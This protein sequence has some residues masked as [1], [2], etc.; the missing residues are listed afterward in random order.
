[1][2]EEVD[3]GQE[4]LTP[5]APVR[6]DPNQLYCVCRQPDDP[7]NP[8]DYIQ[9]DACQEWFHPECVD[10]TLEVKPA[11]QRPLYPA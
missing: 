5:V 2:D 1:M 11:V 7:D 6:T 9:C 10:V 4:P 8:R 3:I